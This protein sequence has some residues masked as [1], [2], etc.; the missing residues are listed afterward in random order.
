MSCAQYW[1]TKHTKK[2]SFCHFIR[3]N[4]K[5]IKT[6]SCYAPGVQSRKYWNH[7]TYLFY[8]NL[9]H[10]NISI[11]RLYLPSQKFFTFQFYHHIQYYDVV[12]VA[13]QTKSWAPID[14]TFFYCLL[15][16]DKLHIIHKHNENSNH[17]EYE[18]SFCIS[19]IVGC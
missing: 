17:V 5:I 9:Y 10:S 16:L 6:I 7:E 14:M 11:T 8:I 13:L 19:K 15:Y 4:R 1:K 2:T 12:T 3:T 18:N